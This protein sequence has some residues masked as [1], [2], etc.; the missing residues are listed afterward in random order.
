MAV[1]GAA[2]TS[3]EIIARFSKLKKTNFH[4]LADV[5]HRTIGIEICGPLA[6]TTLNAGC[7]LDLENM[8]VGRC[9]RTVLDKAEII[10]MKLGEQGYRLE[11]V[12]SFAPYVWSFL[13]K[14]GQGFVAL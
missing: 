1:A 8:E 14:G 13:R 9:T 10:L 12:R 6:Q 11:I 4:S 2:K 3:Q 5:S 7:P